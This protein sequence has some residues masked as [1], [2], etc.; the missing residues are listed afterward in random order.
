MRAKRARVLKKRMPS[1]VRSARTTKRKATI[2]RKRR[3]MVMAGK[4]LTSQRQESQPSCLQ[5]HWAPKP[6][7]R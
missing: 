4:K 5:P 3:A 7:K 1:L 2:P 6:L